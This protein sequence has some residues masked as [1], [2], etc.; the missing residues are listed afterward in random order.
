M[1]KL[2]SLALV[3]LVL[4]PQAFASRARLLALGMD[5]IDN[6]GS[7]YIHDM[8]NIFLN[9]AYVNDYSDKVIME[10]G[11]NGQ[12]VGNANG[13]ASV[14]ADANPKMQGG[15]LKSAGDFV[16]GAYFGNE[17]NTASLL[18]VVGSSATAANGVG[19]NTAQLLNTP[20]NQLDLF[21]GSS[22][23]DIQWGA[24]L[25]YSN[26]E[27]EEINSKDHGYG[28]RFGLK[29]DRW[30][31]FA[32]VSLG[33]KATRTV[34]LGQAASAVTQEFKGKF[35]LHVG[36][37][38]DITEY[39]TIYGYYKGFNWEQTDSVGTVGGRGQIGTVKGGFNTYSVGY[40]QR[41]VAD[42]GTFFST[43]YYKSQKVEVKF[44]NKAE[45]ENVTIPLT[46]GYEAP[47]TSWLTLRGSVSQNLHGTRTNKNYASLNAVAEQLAIAN[48][49]ADTAGK[50]ATLV[51]STEVRAGASLNFG[52]LVVDG[53]IGTAVVG[54]LSLDQA[55]TRVAATYSF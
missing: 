17:S 11:N 3:V 45:A 34:P 40:G 51:N 6:E 52:K 35:G 16:Y 31:A 32:N 7:Y 12:S 28:S 13:R 5:E 23:G 41:M 49:G 47:A 43:I 50:D 19:A 33:N 48:F 44:T 1:K 30:N 22:F 26:N 25:V 10:W 9:S 53:M 24:N 38:Y 20:D 14:D 15:F 29:A 36:G 27:N 54:S 37:G 46:F 42:H 4:S 8:R 39:G 21:L 18:R 2:L 55:L